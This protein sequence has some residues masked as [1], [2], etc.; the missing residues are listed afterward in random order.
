M[1][2]IFDTETT[3]KWVFGAPT[4]ASCQPKLLQ[5]GALLMDGDV[6]KGRIDLIINHHDI[7]YIPEEAVRVHGITVERMRAEGVVI[8]EAVDKFINLGE[9]ADRMVAHNIEFD[10]KV[11]SKALYDLGVA[12]PE[13]DF[14]AVVPSVM[15]LPK[16]CTM[17]SS[18][19]I[20]RIPGPRGFKWPTLMEAYKKLVDAAGFDNAH[21]AF[22]DMF[23][24]YKV[25]RALEAQNVRL[26]A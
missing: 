21:D 18:T 17:K 10:Y 4:H 19:N 2:L 1:D 22:A 14:L 25:L 20:C 11:M 23:A 26:V 6:E 7:D 9:Q 13:D 16:V 3:G 12:V 24:C 5:L 15:K 8:G